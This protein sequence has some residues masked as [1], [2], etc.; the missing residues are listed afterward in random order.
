MNQINN[1]VRMPSSQ[2]QYQL[3]SACSPTYAKPTN[4]GIKYGSYMR[5]IYRRRSLCQS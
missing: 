2:Y 4:E 5:V 3:T 1:Q